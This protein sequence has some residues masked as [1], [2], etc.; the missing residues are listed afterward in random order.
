MRY[1]SVF[2]HGCHLGISA[3]FVFPKSKPITAS[4]E[5]H[6][7]SIWNMSLSARHQPFPGLGK[8]IHVN[9]RRCALTANR[10]HQVCTNGKSLAVH[11]QYLPKIAL[12][13]LAWEGG[14][15]AWVS[16]W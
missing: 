6:H 9:N 7:C 12:V 10:R 16:N 4:G 13:T 14:A 11:E 3:R 5:C 15:L 1:M 8:R 2:G